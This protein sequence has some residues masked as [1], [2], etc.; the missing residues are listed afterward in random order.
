MTPERPAVILASSGHTLTYA[1]LESTSLRIARLLRSH[2]LTPGKRVAIMLGNEALFLPVAWAAQRA[3]LRFIPVSPDLTAGEAVHIIGDCRAEA[4][5]AGASALDVAAR[6]PAERLPAVRVRF[7]AGVAAAASGWEDLDAGSRA[8]GDGPLDD[9]CEG[10]CMPY[11]SGTTG[12][13]KGIK[14]PLTLAPLGAGPDGAGLFL[15]KIGVRPGSVVLITASLCHSAALSWALS[16]LRRGATVVE[17]ERF[18]PEVALNALERYQVTHS[19]WVPTMF[20][21][22]LAATREDRQRWRF[23]AHRAAVHGAGPCAPDVK[24]QMLAWWGPVL[25]EYYSCTE[26]IGAT[27]IGPDDWMAHP[28]SVGRPVLGRVV[29]R[30]E[31]GREVP[32]GIVGG[33]WFAQGYPYA[34]ENDPA[35]TKMSQNRFGEVTVGDIG[36]VDTGGYLY[37]TGRKAHTVISGGVNIYP[38]EIE[39]CIMSHPCVADVAVLG[40]PDAEYGERLVAAVESARGDVAVSELQASVLAHCRDH[41]ARFKVPR[42]VLVV[43][44]LPRD[45]AGKIARTRLAALIRTAASSGDG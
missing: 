22:L 20:T 37:L 31:S 44:S 4:L 29:I 16:A 33:I 40:V 45:G 43:D 12:S 39:D 17:L 18:S 6:L 24:R 9:E 3:G 26:G 36:Y 30:D 34:Y 15:D 32:R 35:K 2:G 28:G 21:R 14:R 1:Q 7:T 42:A 27:L 19:Q 8:I 41:L 23:P 5:V 38:R 10:D 11:S 13:P 25:W